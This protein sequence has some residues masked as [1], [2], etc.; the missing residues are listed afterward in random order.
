MS[1]DANSNN[2]S[3]TTSNP[4]PSINDI[5]GCNLDER[6]NA[7]YKPVPY[8]LLMRLFVSCGWN[9][10]TKISLKTRVL[11]R[12]PLVIVERSIGCICI[13]VN[14]NTSR[15]S[16]NVCEIAELNVCVSD[17]SVAPTKVIIKPMKKIITDMMKGRTEDVWAKQRVHLLLQIIDRKKRKRRRIIRTAIQITITCKTT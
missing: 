4:E 11:E 3:S 5:A 12:Y 9:A 10:L 6:F 1:E 14:P 16:L 7:V 13:L 8:S 15:A 2:V 17:E